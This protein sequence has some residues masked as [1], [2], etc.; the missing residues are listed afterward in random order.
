MSL[1][2]QTVKMVNIVLDTAKG[3][4]HANKHHKQLTQTRADP[5]DAF[6]RCKHHKQLRRPNEW[7]NQLEPNER[8]SS[9]QIVCTHKRLRVSETYT[10]RS[11]PE[12]QPKCAQ[13]NIQ[14]HATNLTYSTTAHSSTNVLPRKT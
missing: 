2:T 13:N 4:I 6:Q 10:G 14:L 12:T 7:L 8:T 9:I 3:H 11:K 1:G 5:F